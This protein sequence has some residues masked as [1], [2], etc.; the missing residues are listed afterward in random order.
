MLPIKKFRTTTFI[1][2]TFILTNSLFAQNSEAEKN[3]AA[4]ENGIEILRRYFSEEKN[5]HSTTPALGENVDGLIHF[6]EDEP[7]DSVLTQLNGFLND[8]SF[9]FVFRLPENVSDSLS[10]QGYF[11]QARLNA[12]MSKIENRLQAKY[13]RNDLPIPPSVFDGIE[14]KAGVI[15]PENGMQL[16]TSLG[17]TMPD[18]LIMPDVISDSLLENTK[19]YER[20]L[21]LD[22]IRADYVEQKRLA[23]NDSV[24]KAFR[25]SVEFQYRQRRFD[26]EYLLEK[27][28]LTDSV[29]LNNYN[30]LK[31]YNDA[32]IAAVNDTI[33]TALK[34]LTNYADYID[35]SKIEIRNLVDQSYG[36][37]LSNQNDYFNRI[38]LK[39]EQNDSL[40]ILVK[41]LDKRTIQMLIDDGVTISRFKA[42]ETKKFDFNGILPEQPQF[43]G[44][45]EKYKLI[46][47][48][49]LTGDGNFGFTQTYLSNWKAGGNSAISLL[50]VLKG[51]ANYKSKNEDVQ[52]ENSLEL[53]NG[54]IR[55]GKENQKNS[56]KIEF[57][58]KFGY[59]AFK[60]WYYS[61]EVDVK[62]QLF[63]GY[64]YSSGELISGFMSPITTTFKLG[65]DYKPNSN[66]SLL[67]SPLTSKT[68]YVKDTANVDQTTYGISENSKRLWK[69]GLNVDLT[70]K[71][72]FGTNVTYATSYD[73]FINYRAP[74]SKFDINWENTITAKLT[75]AINMTFRLYVLYDD[76]VTFA[77]NKVDAEGNTI[78][79]AKWQI[80]EL[81]TLGFSYNIN[82]V[83]RRT[84][85]IR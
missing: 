53:N 71:K 84:I 60:K 77:T 82:K 33:Y 26:Q 74:F 40:S 1:F 47:P 73:M 38:W 59:S 16:F 31:A 8:T 14:E 35:T 4:L 21:K 27:K 32:V 37:Q 52:W 19:S 10:V 41:N 80:K 5:W 83:V 48:W 54:W 50:T 15:P 44:V 58:S 51:E 39:N 24:V 45:K 13:Q 81:V 85:R 42:K 70:Y 66:L 55:Q 36:L 78:Y 2:L 9:S 12:E 30:V 64:N 23:Y 22:S 29:K 7:I 20:L 63:N 43:S 75:D 34:A 17:Y 62:T 11:S 25:D 57:I 72:K 49:T 46:T 6:I 3:A 69:P 79:K 67:L 61:A 68:V 76:D 65:M 18:S 28:N 56:D